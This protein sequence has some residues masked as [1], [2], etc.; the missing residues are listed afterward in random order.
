MPSRRRASWATAPNPVSVESV[1]LET[2]GIDGHAHDPERRTARDQ[3]KTV[4]TTMEGT[5]D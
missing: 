5:V 4:A 1:K 2:V 3:S